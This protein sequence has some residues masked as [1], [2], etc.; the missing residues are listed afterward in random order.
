MPNTKFEKAVASEWNGLAI[1]ESGN[2]YVWGENYNDKFHVETDE[3][4]I[5]SPVLIL[6]NIKFK[7]LYAGIYKVLAI[8]ES[9]NEWLDLHYLD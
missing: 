6:K 2:L 9:G 5:L 1:S 8:D 3:S 7:N 4:Y